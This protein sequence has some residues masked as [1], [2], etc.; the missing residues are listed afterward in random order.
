MDQPFFWANCAVLSLGL[1]LLLLQWLTYSLVLVPKGH[2]LG[3][4]P[5]GEITLDCTFAVLPVYW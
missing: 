5:A 1:G 2:G 3:L 4:V